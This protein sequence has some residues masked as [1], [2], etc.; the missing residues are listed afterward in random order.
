LGAIVFTLSIFL[1]PETLHYIVL[2][3]EEEA[4]KKSQ[5][6]I[7]LVMT[8]EIPSTEPI[9]VMLGKP[10]MQPPWQPLFYLKDPIISYSAWFSGVT[11]SILYLV[12]LLYRF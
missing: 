5:G 11:V 6:S 10:R 9:E 12:V 4:R 8:S 2:K 1:V 3:K 7:N